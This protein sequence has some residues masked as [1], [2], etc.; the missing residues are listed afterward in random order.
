M[1]DGKDLDEIDE[2]FPEINIDYVRRFYKLWKKNNLAKINNSHVSLKSNGIFITKELSVE[3]QDKFFRKWWLW[4]KRTEVC[5]DYAFR[6]KEALEN[7]F[8]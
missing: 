5:K 6:I 7:N 2:N 3:I 8:Q 1:T 4:D